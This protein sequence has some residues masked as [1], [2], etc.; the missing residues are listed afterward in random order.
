MIEKGKFQVQISRGFP[1]VVN[2]VEVEL[3]HVVIYSRS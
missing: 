1:W 2:L 3:H